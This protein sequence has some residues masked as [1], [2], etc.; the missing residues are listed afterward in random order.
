MAA[1][2]LVAAGA[3]GEAI[4][5]VHAKDTRINAAIAAVNGQIDVTPMDRLEARA[6]SYVTLGDGH[7]AGWWRRFCAALRDAGYDDVLSIEHEDVVLPAIEGVR[8]S[9][10][11]LREVVP[12]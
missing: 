5:H 4:Y 6:W 3:L 8:R 11:L 10:A 7:D 9:V 12:A 1:D 2:P